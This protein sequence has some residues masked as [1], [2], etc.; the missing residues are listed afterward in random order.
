[1]AC[2]RTYRTRAIVLDRTKLGEQDLILS[3][4]A[5]DGS[6][7]R[8][9]AKGARKPGGRL[10][11]RAELFCETDFLVSAGRSLDVVSEASLVE[12]HAGLRGEYERVAA[13]SAIAEVAQLTCFEDA[14]DGFLYPICS[15]ALR[16]C[17]EAP[18]QPRLDLT[19]AA[20]VM[21]V[22][23]HGGWRPELEGCC[24]CGDAAVTY[25]SSVA[26]GAL[27]ESCA[28]EVAGAQE[29]SS[30]LLA[31]LRSLISCTFDEL[32]VSDIEAETA[33][34]LLGVAHSWAATHLDARLRAM[35]FLAG[36]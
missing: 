7:A 33:V 9:V 28:R 31:W 13:A 17:E 15:R 1:M 12:A 30:V 26:G 27:C 19:V 24:A 6:A 21:K 8:A 20:Y 3:L 10:A 16:A 34:F 35:E 2:R 36:V 29:L 25:F 11:A 14:P 23:A 32:L 5:Q 18:D 4:L 22:L